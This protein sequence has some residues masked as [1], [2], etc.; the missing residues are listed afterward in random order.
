MGKALHLTNLNFFMDR[1]DDHDK[2]VNCIAIDNTDEYLFKVRRKLLGNESDV[3]VH[4][5]DAYRYSLAEFFARPGQLKTGSY[6]V[7]GMPHADVSSEVIE[8][9]RKYGIGVGHI[10]KFM[11]ALNHKNLWEYKSP[12]ER[13]RR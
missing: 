13:Q 1:M 5:A 11:G 10:G 6:V 8:E 7:L 3:I 2:V 9:A 12:E 4:L